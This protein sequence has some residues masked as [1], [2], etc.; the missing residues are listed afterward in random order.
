MSVQTLQQ[1]DGP[2]TIRGFNIWM[3]AG[4]GEAHTSPRSNSLTWKFGLG[5]LKVP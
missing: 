5:V 1:K 4:I 2:I 3:L